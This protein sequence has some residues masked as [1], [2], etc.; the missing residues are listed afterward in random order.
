MPATVSVTIPAYNAGGRVTR[1]IASALDQ[2]MP[3]LEVIVVDDGSTDDTVEV[4]SRFPHPVRIVRKSNGGP[5]SA[6]NL[7]CG[8]AQGDWLA[9]LDADDWWFPRK[10]EIQL[11][12]AAAN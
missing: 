2:T 5:A 4:A 7:G 1:T 12:H 10:N 3:V 9:M 11:A 8:L 6:R